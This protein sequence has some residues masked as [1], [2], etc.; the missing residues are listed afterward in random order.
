M[1]YQFNKNISEIHTRINYDLFKNLEDCRKIFQEDIIKK[2]KEIRDNLLKNFDICK[3]KKNAKISEITDIIFSEK[4][5]TIFEITKDFTKV[6][7]METNNKIEK[8]L[9]INL[10]EELMNQNKDIVKLKDIIKRISSLFE[11]F[12]EFKIPKHNTLNE[13]IKDI[14]LD[15]NNDYDEVIYFMNKKLEKRISKLNDSELDCTKN[16]I[17]VE[18]YF[19]LLLK[20]YEQETQFLKK[21]M[22]DYEEESIKYIFYEDIELK[23]NEMNE[24][25][26]KKFGENNFT[27]LTMSIKDNFKIDNFD[28]ISNILNK[29]INEPIIFDK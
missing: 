22:K 16:D 24:L 29:I 7:V 25:F 21:I 6:F 27:N 13:H 26:E 4:D 23:L 14:I 12:L 11:D 3:M 9:E 15:E 17:L 18:S 8:F 10:S 5:K 1:R 20:T 19:L 28:N 2:V